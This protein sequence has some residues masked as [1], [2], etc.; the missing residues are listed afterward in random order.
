M[1]SYPSLFPALKYS[2]NEDRDERHILLWMC[3]LIAINQLG[4]GGVLPVLP[5]YAE[6]FG[7]SQTYIGIAVSI[8]GLARVIIALPSGYL[9]DW[10][11]PEKVDGLVKSRRGSF[12]RG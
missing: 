12:K 9:A 1:P 7:V 5:I 11:C 10:Y 4:F 2:T 6:S 8:Y 3:V